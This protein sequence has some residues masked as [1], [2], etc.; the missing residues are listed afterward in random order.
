VQTIVGSFVHIEGQ[1][2]KKNGDLRVQLPGAH[3][4]GILIQGKKVSNPALC[5][6]PDTRC[7]I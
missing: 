2:G 6:Q 4:D 1:V 5:S 7:Q 3:S